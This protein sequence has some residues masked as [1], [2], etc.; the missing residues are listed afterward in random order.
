VGDVSD[1]LKTIYDTVLNAQIKGV[2]GTKAGLTGKAADQ[3]TREYI[4]DKGYGQYFGHSTGHG[5][6]LEV[7]ELPRLAP[8][9]EQVLEPGMVVTIEPGIYVPEVGGCRIEDDIVIKE[10]GNELLT[11]ARKDFIQTYIGG[12]QMIS[13]NDIK[14]GTTIEGGD[15]IWQVVEFQHV[16]RGEGAAFVRSKVRNL[17]DGN[18]Q[19]EALRA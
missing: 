12:I 2:E 18:I 5:L 13:V 16:K 4:T 19:D 17:R 8:R 10:D 6:G 14:T 3:L 15:S 11:H 7:H 9:A 1:E